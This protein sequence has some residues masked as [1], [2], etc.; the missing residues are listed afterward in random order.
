MDKY[1]K[2]CKICGNTPKVN[3]LQENLFE[4]HCE[5]YFCCNDFSVI[6]PSYDLIVDA[7][8]EAQDKRP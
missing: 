8:N 3:K 1:I 4:L 5:L 6:S 2:P 7:W